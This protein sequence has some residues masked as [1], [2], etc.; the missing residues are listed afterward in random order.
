[1]FARLT[2][3]GALVALVV[4]PL[5]LVV[6][7]IVQWT[8]QPTGPDPTTTAVAQQFPTAWMAVGLL[9]V[10][11]PLVWLG[12]LPAA[13]ALAVGR[14]LVLTRIGALVTGVGLSAA[15]GHLAL[16]FGLFG[17]TALSGL[18]PA[19]I[20]SVEAAADREPLGN[21]LLVLFLVA[22]SLGPI[23]LTVGLRIARRVA[24]WVPIAAIL[25]AGANLFG[26]PIAGVVQLVCL[27]AAWGAI[28]VAVARAG[29]GRRPAAPVVAS[30]SPAV[31]TATQR[32]L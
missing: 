32:G 26:G 10:L 9:S 22:Y 19:S 29:E 28:V 23:L 15:I 8:L 7:S 31:S 16:F 6:T 30:A 2:R 24:V 13:G 27:V 14:G 12:G 25:T 18:D 1:M 5:T 4:G 20:G 17:T 11:G 21:M 3:I